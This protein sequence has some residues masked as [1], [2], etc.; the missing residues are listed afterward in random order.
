MPGKTLNHFAGSP[1]TCHFHFRRRRIPKH[2]G[3]KPGPVG[4]VDQQAH[5]LFAL[6][7]GELGNQRFG[8]NGF[9]AERQDGVRR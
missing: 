5:N 2:L 3:D 7:S 6:T 9:H 1:R 8:G 4:V